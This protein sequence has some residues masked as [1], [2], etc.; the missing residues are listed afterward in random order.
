MRRIVFATSYRAELFREAF[1]DGS[2]F[3]LELV[4]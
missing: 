1:G 3:G 4:T 2:A